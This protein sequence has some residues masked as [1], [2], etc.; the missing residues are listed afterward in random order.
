[1]LVNTTTA[2]A[3]KTSTNIL[4][5]VTNKSSHNMPT[6]K[7]YFAA[8]DKVIASAGLNISRTESAYFPITENATTTS[9][10]IELSTNRTTTTI[11]IELATRT[12]TTVVPM[13]LATRTVTGVPIELTRTTRAV[14]TEFTT[15]TTTMIP[16]ELPTI[17]TTTVVPT[18]LP[19]KIKTNHF[20]DNL[21][22][23]SSEPEI[24]MKSNS[25]ESTT[26]RIIEITDNSIELSTKLTS[27]VNAHLS[28]KIL[29]V[30][31]SNCNQTR[32]HEA[33]QNG[34][35]KLVKELLNTGANVYSLDC[36][37]LTPMH[38]AVMEKGE[39]ANLI[40]SLV[41]NKFDVNKRLQ[42]SNTI[43]FFAVTNG[44]YVS[45]QML[46]RFGSKV[47]EINDEGS[48]PLFQAILQNRTDVTKLLILSGANINIRLPGGNTYMHRSIDVGNISI[49]CTLWT[50]GIVADSVNEI[51]Q[52]A[53]TKAVMADNS[54]MINELVKFG[55]N[56]NRK[57]KS[58]DTYLHIAIKNDKIVA[59]R[60][61]LKN[62]L[63]LES[64]GEYGYSPLYLAALKDKVD[65]LKVLKDFQADFNQVYNQFNSTL[66]HI[67]SGGN[68]V[69][70]VEW[71][72]KNGLDVDIKNSLGWTPLYEACVHQNLGAAK[73][74]LELGA[75]I[76]CKSASG[77]TPLSA[78]EYN[79]PTVLSAYLRSNGATIK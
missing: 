77:A 54:T 31:T 46:I 71:L 8:T 70:A 67:A 60:A 3:T 18:E 17:I 66:L 29:K 38:Y 55:A 13:E 53:L 61:L 43:L 11:P 21:I 15:K 48:T 74:L 20:K 36:K 64:Q 76:N 40:I 58:G 72:V 2:S 12:T 68:S 6:T 37:G 59:M 25:F 39:N 79:M 28:S 49:I 1:M 42:N 75:C 44:T 47:D 56:V 63:P 35:V 65:A 52:T 19:S 27:I 26:P 5:G 24:R 23:F 69:Q 73:K 62:K 32:L 57:S 4:D 50:L 30:F 10:P 45:V 9:K 34:N 7:G 22:A 14:P 33:V 16:T 41:G 51:D 78:A